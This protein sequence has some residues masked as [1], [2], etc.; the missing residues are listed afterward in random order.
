M[1]KL[2]CKNK[3]EDGSLCACTYFEKLRVNEFYDKATNL[4]SGLREVEVDSDIRIYK[5][6]RCRTIILPPVEYWNTS[7]DNKKVYL[8]LQ[9]LIDG[10]KVK[11]KISERIRRTQPGN[12]DFIKN[13]VADDPENHGKFIKA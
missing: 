2:I 11:R 7:E 9:E 1:A 6:I 13:S 3:E 12:I 5:C 4:H 10:E 8:E